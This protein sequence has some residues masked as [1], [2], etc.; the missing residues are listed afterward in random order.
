MT[1]TVFITGA[2]G[3]IGGATMRAFASAGWRVIAADL[4][5]DRIEPIL[6][7]YVDDGHESVVLDVADA[8]AV[9][10][11]IDALHERHERIDALVNVAGL[12]QDIVTLEELDD[13]LHRRIWD[14]NY[15][16]T[17]HCCRAF[18]PWMREAGGG[19]IVNISSINA[20]RPLP[21]LAY[22]PSKVA[23]AALTEILA[24]ELGPAGIRVNAV[25]P[26]FTLTPAFQKKIDTG[27]RDPAA[28]KAA[29]ALRRMV[30]PDEVADA[31]LFLCSPAARAITGTSLVVDAGWTSS[32]HHLTYGMSRVAGTT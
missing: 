17:F 2:G 3:G 14:V 24:A 5:T 31:I 15:F 32:V 6:D 30:E 13:T 18:A 25:A 21:L 7:E 1:K 23:V 10:A 16:G 11:V 19:S 26:G 29:A 27:Q 20:H 28:M 4:D 22:A 8:D 12:L 9:D